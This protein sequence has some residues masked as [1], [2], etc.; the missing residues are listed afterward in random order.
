[1]EPKKANDPDELGGWLISGRLGE[2]AFGT[3]FLAQKGAQKAAIKVIRDLM[4]EEGLERFQLEIAALKKLDDP[5]IAKI[6]DSGLESVIPWFATEFVNGPTLDEKVKYEGV[7]EELAWLNLASNLFHALLT[8]HSSGVV[9]K[10][11]KPSNIILGETG[12]KLIDFGIA[13]VTG[14]TRIV[15][16]GEFEGSRPYSSPESSTGKSLPGMDVFSAAVTLAF[17]AKGKTI[18]QGNTELQLMRSINEDEPDLS[19]LTELQRGFLAPLL[20]KNISERPSSEAAYK[21]TLDLIANYGHSKNRDT[22]YNWAPVSKAKNRKNRGLL[23][24]VGNSIVGIF[25]LLGLLL[26]G[27]RLT[28]GSNF[29]TQESSGSVNTQSPSLVADPKQSEPLSDIKI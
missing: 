8:S 23:F 11:V 28:S 29:S 18:W 24:Y 15:N 1:M 13:H 2:G 6:L 10:D 22:F 16:V 5:Y 26:S 12:N 4:D 19:G 25:L 9:H 17:A 14:H 20:N 3:V 7:L 27:L 21:K